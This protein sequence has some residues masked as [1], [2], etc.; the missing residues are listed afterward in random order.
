MYI[1]IY[2]IVYTCVYMHIGYVCVYI[3]SMYVSIYMCVWSWL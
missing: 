1:Y 3:Y 2:L